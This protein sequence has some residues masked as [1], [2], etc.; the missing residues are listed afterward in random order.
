[1]NFFRFHCSPPS[2][3]RDPST[4]PQSGL[5]PRGAA[6]DRTRPS[7]SLLP[8][9]FPCFVQAQPCAQGASKRQNSPRFAQTLLFAQTSALRVWPSRGLLRGQGGAGGSRPPGPRQEE[10][11]TSVSVILSIRLNRH[12]HLGNCSKNQHFWP[13]V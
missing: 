6:G 10:K 3:S 8:L 11:V 9:P 1:M 13:F 7:L 5:K 2:P 4:E 12:S